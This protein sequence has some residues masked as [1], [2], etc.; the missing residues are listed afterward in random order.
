MK[1]F[2]SFAISAN[3]ASAFVNKSKLE[4]DATTDEALG[5]DDFVINDAMFDKAPVDLLDNIEQKQANVKKMEEIVSIEDNL[6]S[7]FASEDK[8]D[9][10]EIEAISSL[11]GSEWQEFVDGIR[12]E[13]EE[14]TR[15]GIESMT[16]EEIDYLITELSTDLDTHKL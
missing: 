6:K 10:S 15:G 16:D 13:V 11:T 4:I 14:L 8:L 5:F 3:L 2:T 7:F 1:L 12:N 9:K